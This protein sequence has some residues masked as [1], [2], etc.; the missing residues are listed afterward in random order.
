L[1]ISQIGLMGKGSIY[2]YLS[3]PLATFLIMTLELLATFMQA[4][5]LH[6]VEWFLKFYKG[7]GYIFKPFQL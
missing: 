1:A 3:L 2:I 5:R 6:W 4:L 7:E